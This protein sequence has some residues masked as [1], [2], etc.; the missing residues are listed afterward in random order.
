ME[1]N[2]TPVG[3]INCSRQIYKNN[4]HV[5]IKCQD[6][7]SDKFW[8]AIPDEGNYIIIW[9]RNGKTPQK[10]QIVSKYVA[11]DRLEE[12]LRKG[13]DFC[14]SNELLYHF[15]NNPKWFTKVVGSPQFNSAVKA[16][17]LQLDLQSKNK[18]TNERKQK[19]KI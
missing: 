19:L 9:G 16:Q 11:Q 13:Y 18:M 10:S 5:L 8:A 3:L 15:E 17:Q 1:N 7:T 4:E 6:G 14:F 2:F 12:K